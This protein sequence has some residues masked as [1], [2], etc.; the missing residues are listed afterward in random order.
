MWPGICKSKHFCHKYLF[1]YLFIICLVWMCFTFHNITI[2][3]SDLLSNPVTTWTMEKK[4]RFMD[5][6]KTIQYIYYLLLIHSIHN[7]ALFFQGNTAL[8]INLNFEPKVT[9]TE[10]YTK[11]QK[12]V[13]SFWIQALACIVKFGQCFERTKQSIRIS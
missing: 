9:L 1:I 2:T 11:R 6:Y 7:K 5:F 12:I 4:Y 3:W 13:I 8:M 10:S